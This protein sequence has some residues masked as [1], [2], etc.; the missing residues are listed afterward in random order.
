M[1]DSVLHSVSALSDAYNIGKRQNYIATDDPD[2][3][4]HGNDVLELLGYFAPRATYNLYRVIAGDGRVK[5]GTVVDAIGDASQDGVD[6]LNLSVSVYHR[7][8]P[9][10]SCGGHCRIADETRLATEAGTTVIAATG[11]RKNDDPRAVYC[12][13]LLD[14]AIGVGGFVARCRH[15]LVDD[16]QSGQYWICENSTV[17]GPYCGQRG[18]RPDQEC[19]DHRYEYPWRG[20]VSFHN[21][22]PEILAP[23]HHP[24]L[25][26]ETP[27]LQSGTSFGTPAV[28]G[29][30]ATILSVFD[31]AV[32]PADVKR[33]V[34]LGATDIDGRGVAEVR[35]R[36]NTSTVD[37]LSV[38]GSGKQKLC[39]G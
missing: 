24:V 10:G 9:G 22:V 39:L 33:A 2:T 32:E 4:H 13:A 28:A 26:Q 14:E 21:A 11:H 19:P 17:D 20:N 29:I 37:R 3:T 6:L 30:L 15:E 35:W 18:C 36:R 16:E 12:P 7:E 8:E 5:R 34:Q 23:V 38:T 1:V 27:V 31:H 25:D